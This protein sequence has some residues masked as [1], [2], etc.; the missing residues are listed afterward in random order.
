MSKLNEIEKN[1]EKSKTDIGT[2]P[3]ISADI[4][5][6]LPYSSFVSIKLYESDWTAC[7]LVYPPYA[8]HGNT[9]EAITSVKGGL[10]PIVVVGLGGGGGGAT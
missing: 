4:F 3:A 6:T 8:E 5:L 10:L 2:I 7:S 1:V 9:N